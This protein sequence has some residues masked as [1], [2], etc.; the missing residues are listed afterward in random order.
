MQQWLQTDLKWTRDESLADVKSAEFVD[1]PEMKIKHSALAMQS[2]ITRVTRHLEDARVSSSEKKQMATPATFLPL[3][4]LAPISIE[5][6]STLST[7][8]NSCKG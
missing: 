6:Y 7:R 1:L 3:L 5:F 8:L 4:E 2:F